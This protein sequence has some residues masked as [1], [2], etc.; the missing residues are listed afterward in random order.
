M[1]N[2]RAKLMARKMRS[3]CATFQPGKNETL[4]LCS[5]KLG[6]PCTHLPHSN[7]RL[8][9]VAA[10]ALMQWLK[11]PAWKVRDRGFETHSGLKVSKKKKCFFPA[12]LKSFII[13]HER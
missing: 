1:D 6:P 3:H 9:K 7:A 10:G 8:L 12:H 11:L 2:A 4:T 5:F 13:L